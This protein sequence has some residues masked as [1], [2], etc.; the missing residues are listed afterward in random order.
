MERKKYF[1]KGI[2]KGISVAPDVI[3]GYT[4]MCAIGEEAVV[5]ADGNFMLR[6][7]QS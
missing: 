6:Q 2:F 5:L 3:I 1:V 4:N 7:L